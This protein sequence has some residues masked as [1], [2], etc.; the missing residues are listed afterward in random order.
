MKEKTGKVSLTSL[1]P[2]GTLI[3]FE[4]GYE[5]TEQKSRSPFPG[6]ISLLLNCLRWRVFWETK[7]SDRRKRPTS[8][9]E[10]GWYLTLNELFIHYK[11]QQELALE[12]NVSVSGIRSDD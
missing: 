3:H 2:S 11:L 12:I 5:Q 9:R 4:K 7:S 10:R 6:L 8:P 1:K